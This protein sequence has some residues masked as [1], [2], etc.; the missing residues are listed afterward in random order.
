VLG[1]ASIDAGILGHDWM[2]AT[3][4]TG[5]RRY[6]DPAGGSERPSALS[7]PALTATYPP[8]A[9]EARSLASLLPVVTAPL[10]VSSVPGS[11][12]RPDPRLQRSGVQQ[13]GTLTALH[14]HSAAVFS[15]LTG[16][17]LLGA[18][19][20]ERKSDLSLRGGSPAGNVGPYPEEQ[21]IAGMTSGALSRLEFEAEGAPLVRADQKRPQLEDEL[22]GAV[23]GSPILPEELL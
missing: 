16:A 20:P 12:G 7:T 23:F 19:L 22:L 21:G 17:S 13:A 9:D 4:G 2:T 6:P 15:G 10:E 5:V 1:F 11:Q 8:P 18:L 14:D 3:L